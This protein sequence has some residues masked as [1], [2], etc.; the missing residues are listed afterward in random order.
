MLRSSCFSDHTIILSL[1]FWQSYQNNNRT[2][3]P[4]ETVTD[5]KTKY[6][7]AECENPVNMDT[8]GAGRIVRINGVPVLINSRV[9]FYDNVKYIRNKTHFNS[10][11]TF[12]I[13]FPL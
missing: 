7:H 3:I 2:E 13:K 8:K 12:S 6:F 4:I 1:R 5:I 11:R 10:S 9:E